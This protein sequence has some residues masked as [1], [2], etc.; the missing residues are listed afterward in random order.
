VARE[1][2]LL[3][4]LGEVAVLDRVLGRE[5][6]VACDVGERSAAVAGRTP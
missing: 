3:V 4:A 6:A 5:V 2:G 1:G